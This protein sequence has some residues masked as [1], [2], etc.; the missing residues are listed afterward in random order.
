MG[1]SMHLNQKETLRDLSSTKTIP[2][3]IMYRISKESAYLKRAS[4]T[5]A[6]L[7]IENNKKVCLK[8]RINH[9]NPNEMFI[10]MYGEVHIDET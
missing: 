5:V 9:L 4:S 6:S 7:V 1:K 3:T 2:K 10:S 8:Y